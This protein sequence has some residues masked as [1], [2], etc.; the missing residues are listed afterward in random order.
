M[1]A[2]KRTGTDI[3]KYTLLTTCIYTVVSACNTFSL[4]CKGEPF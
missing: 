4:R 1:H 3:D 2:L